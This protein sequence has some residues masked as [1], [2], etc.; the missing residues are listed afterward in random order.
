MFL[1]FYLIFS[2]AIVTR[3]GNGQLWSVIGRSRSVKDLW[4]TDCG[5][6]RNLDCGLTDGLINSWPRFDRRFDRLLNQNLLK[7][8]F[9]MKFLKRKNV[10]GKKFTKEPFFGKFWFKNRLNCRSN[11]GQPSVKP[12]SNRRSNRGQPSVG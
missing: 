10:F 3:D 9:L 6:N 5:H 1:F 2:F 8:R 4:L 11:R 12:R 7:K